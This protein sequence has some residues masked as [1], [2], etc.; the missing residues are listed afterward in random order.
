[1][2]QIG[3]AG[4]G[5]A[6]DLLPAIIAHSRLD[7]GRFGGLVEFERYVARRVQEIEVGGIQEGCG[8]AGAAAAENISTLSAV[9]AAFED[10]ESHVAVEVIAHR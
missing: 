9:V 2:D 6:V 4:S 3:C 5:A 1:M 7:Y 10:G 8:A